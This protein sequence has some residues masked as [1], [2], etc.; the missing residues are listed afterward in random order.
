[1]GVN[2]NILESKGLHLILYY[3]LQLVKTF[4]GR[5]NC[6]EQ[7]A[8]RAEKFMDEVYGVSNTKIQSLC[9]VPDMERT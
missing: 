2:V 7:V 3:L 4:D 1:M 8:D 5:P 9:D 6:V